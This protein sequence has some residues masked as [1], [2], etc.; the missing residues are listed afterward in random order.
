M[1]EVDGSKYSSNITNRKIEGFG[2]TTEYK[3]YD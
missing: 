1:S 3:L 2:N